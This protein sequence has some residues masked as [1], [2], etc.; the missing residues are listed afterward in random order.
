MTHV[1]TE[2]GIP[3]HNRP[4][5]TRPPKKNDD[6][7]GDACL[8]ATPRPSV[9]ESIASHRLDQPDQCTFLMKNTQMAASVSTMKPIGNRP[10]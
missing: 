9:T 10:A 7:H 2:G 3:S 4:S 1:M 5:F 8:Q 6:G